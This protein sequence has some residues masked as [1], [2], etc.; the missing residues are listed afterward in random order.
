MA[1]TA[2]F[3]VSEFTLRTVLLI[4]RYKSI[5]EVETLESFGRVRLMAVLIG[6]GYDTGAMRFELIPLNSYTTF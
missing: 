6:A 4:I 3:M 1:D 2:D 5:S